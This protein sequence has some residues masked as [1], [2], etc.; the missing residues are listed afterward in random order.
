MSRQHKQNGTRCLAFF[1]VLLGFAFVAQVDAHAAD[2][3][4]TVT[5]ILVPS[6]DA[7]KF[8]LLINGVIKASNV[9]D[10]GTTGAVI[11]PAPTSGF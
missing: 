11:H 1:I 3:T 6:T 7:G 2:P 8:N 4:L 5:K 9:G 10:G